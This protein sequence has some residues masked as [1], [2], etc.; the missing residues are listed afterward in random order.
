M[1]RPYLQKKINT[2]KKKDKLRQMIQQLMIL[3]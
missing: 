1:T 2:Q 3:Y